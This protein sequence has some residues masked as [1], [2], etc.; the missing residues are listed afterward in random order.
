MPRR[1]KKPQGRPRFA[2]S[3]GNQ[4]PAGFSAL[5]A[6]GIDGGAVVTMLGEL[7]LASAPE[8]RKV[9]DEA[10]VY[11][12]DVEVD[13]RACGFVDSM[14]I[15]A[16]VG[17]ARQLAEHGRV[18]R[19]KGAQDRVRKIFELAGLVENDWIELES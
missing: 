6:E 8:L 12:G 13:M 2:T 17:A 15:A 16:M 1:S 9:L 19:I 14:G 5:V 18:L 11:D 3:N 7:D 4:K 10:I